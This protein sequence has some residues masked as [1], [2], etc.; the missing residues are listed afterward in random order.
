MLKSFLSFLQLSSLLIIKHLNW[1]HIIHHNYLKSLLE[2][3]TKK[4]GA[5]R[6]HFAGAKMIEQGKGNLVQNLFGQKKSM[7]LSKYITTIFHQEKE[8]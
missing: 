1:S 8:I 3:R 4:S 6:S 7:F 5:G 2:R